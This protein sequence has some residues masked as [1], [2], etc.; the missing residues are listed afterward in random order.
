MLLLRSEF[1]CTS[2][3][4]DAP[5]TIAKKTTIPI[6]RKEPSTNSRG[7]EDP[8]RKNT[9]PLDSVFGLA[10]S[11]GFLNLWHRKRVRHFSW[12]S[13]NAKLRKAQ[14]T[15]RAHYRS[16]FFASICPHRCER[17]AKVP[18]SFHRQL[19]RW[20]FIIWIPCFFDHFGIVFILDQQQREVEAGLDRL[21]CCVRGYC[22]PDA[23]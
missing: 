22:H 12:N 13:L 7:S 23:R 19:I 3:P 18:R 21:R 2:L 9:Q 20:I 1:T 5:N 11:M 10:G 15:R 17:V 16:A 4:G 6:A 8:T 14:S